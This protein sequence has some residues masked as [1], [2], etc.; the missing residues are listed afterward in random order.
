MLILFC[1]HS[2]EK[3]EK[4]LFCCMHNGKGKYVG[5]TWMQSK[6]FLHDSLHVDFKNSRS[7]YT[8][9]LITGELRQEK[10]AFKKWMDDKMVIYGVKVLIVLIGGLGA[11]MTHKKNKQ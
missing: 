7:N 11:R 4:G 9:H 8:S 2:R 1:A 3:W 5:V 10:W 6:V